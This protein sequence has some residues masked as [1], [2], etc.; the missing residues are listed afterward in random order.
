[1]STTAILPQLRADTGLTD[2]E[3]RTAD[4]ETRRWYLRVLTLKH[5]TGCTIKDAIAAIEQSDLQSE[6]LP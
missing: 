2:E 5:E 3:L 1:M 4:Q 6:P